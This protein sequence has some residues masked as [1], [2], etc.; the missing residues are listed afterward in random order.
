MVR[1]PLILLLV[2]TCLCLVV[3]C[4][5]DDGDDDSAAIG[6]DDTTAE[7][8]S[9]DPIE[10]ALGD[11]ENGPVDC[12]GAYEL[13]P[14]LTGADGLEYHEWELEDLTFTISWALST[15]H[16]TRWI[17]D[18][19]TSGESIRVHPWLVPE[20]GV[21]YRERLSDA[22]EGAV[23]DEPILGK[24]LTAVSPFTHP[25]DNY[26]ELEEA[27]Y[28]P[29]EAEV[30]AELA[31][32]RVIRGLLEQPNEL[33]WSP[34]S[35]TAVWDDDLRDELVAATADYPAEMQ[36]AIARL[37]L[38][39]GEAYLLKEYALREVD[40]DAI[41]R[42]FEQFLA[43]NW[44]T[45]TAAMMG[46]IGGSV[47]EDLAEHAETVPLWP[48]QIGGMAV[49]SA[50][51]VC[52]RALS[53]VEP[54]DS[55]GVDLMTPH[56]RIL[57]DTTGSATV[58]SSAQLADAALVIDLGGD[59]TYHGRYAATHQPWM[60][61]SVLVDVSGNDQYSPD[62][63]DIESE[64]T[65]A[66][67]AFDNDGGFTQG[68]GLFGVGVLVDG[69]G[70]DIYTAT[71]HAQA[72][73]AFGVGVLMDGA[74]SDVYRVG[75][76]GQGTGHFGIG[77]LV[78]GEGNDYY[79]VY[80]MGQGAGKPRGHGVLLDMD[81]DDIYIGYYNEYGDALPG[82]AFNNYHGLDGATWPYSD[83]EGKPH[84]MSVC[85]GV[86]WGYRGD[87]FDD[88]QN[89]AGGFGALLDLGEGN[90]QHYA[91]CMAQGQGYLY[92]L[93]YLYDGGGD[94]LYRTFWWGPAASAH[95]GVNFFEE[96]DGNDDIYVVAL[97]GG[98]G[99]DCSVGWLVDNGGDDTYGGRFN[100]GR[101]YYYGLTFMVNDGGDDVY[102][103]G[104][105]LT[106]PPFGIVDVGAGSANLLG[107]FLDLGSGDDTYVTGDP[108]VGNDSAWHNEPTG[109]DA[110]PDRHK[111]IGIDR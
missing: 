75:T 35:E 85:Q 111:G 57:I 67:E 82:P 25:G 22:A 16:K 96:E 58:W 64:E 76:H 68:C 18:M 30:D 74:G 65:T 5:G 33:P 105:L 81:G 32:T 2:C 52:V 36:A 21:C 43:E 38:A 99:Y 40:D 4:S 51:D 13:P 54:F 86:G 78:D 63:A 49:S 1:F 19:S 106:D 62:V 109:S 24:A 50:A 79:G 107:A 84:Y 47:V 69:E 53:S 28:T 60:S 42:I 98:Y 29:P 37:V 20:A 101:A 83:D 8:P 73:A 88:S 91:D 103:D 39:I 104:G 44:S 45:Q 56:G 31:L 72:N 77:M 11:V 55:P 15:T 34:P 80:S 41:G 48:F 90:D 17:S 97:S 71:V 110:N 27:V 102:N 93:G 95:M 94:D 9:E 87:W 6:D 3:G 100:Y 10:P 59:D 12:T 108:E 46:P 66:A 61:A 14:E 26:D 92:G 23:A 70:D 89:R 7:S